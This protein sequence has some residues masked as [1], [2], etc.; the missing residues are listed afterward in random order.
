MIEMKEIIEG[1]QYRLF[2]NCL[3]SPAI[4][5]KDLDSGEIVTVLQYPTAKQAQEAYNTTVETAWQ[6]AAAKLPNVFRQE[7]IL[8]TIK[9][10]VSSIIES[11]QDED[12]DEI[13]NP[14]YSPA[15]IHHTVGRHI[16]NEWLLWQNDSPL[17]RDAVNTYGIAHADDISDLILEWV[18][19]NVRGMPFDPIAHCDCYHEHWKTYGTNSLAAGGWPPDDIAKAK[20]V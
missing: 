14:N 4:Q 11:L 1:V 19:A 16:R 10:A 12:L 9:A 6:V 20:H 5:V 2:T 15:N 7:P 13:I 17:K 18:F 8:S 3:Q